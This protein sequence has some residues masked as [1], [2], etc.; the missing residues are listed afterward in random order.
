MPDIFPP[1]VG[2]DVEPDWHLV[3]FSLLSVIEMNVCHLQICLVV[4]KVAFNM[5][6][7]ILVH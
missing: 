6:G 4:F 1:A 2:R 3:G 7:V 5:W